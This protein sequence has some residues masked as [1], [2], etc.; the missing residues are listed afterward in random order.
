[1]EFA[2]EITTS[3]V[4]NGVGVNAEPVI[5]A[6]LAVIASLVLSGGAVLRSFCRFFISKLD[7][8]SSG[9]KKGGGALLSV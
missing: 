9:E 5:S 6:Q 3:A 8:S 1:M 2:V 4:T 7:F